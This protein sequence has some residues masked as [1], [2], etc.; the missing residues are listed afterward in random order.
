MP[1]YLF[2]INDVATPYFDRGSNSSWL[3]APLAAVLHHKQMVETA[4]SFGGT[5]NYTEF[6]GD[7]VPEVTID[8][9]C[10]VKL[11]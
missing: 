7:F 11:F 5:D 6:G 9:R 8:G 3:T 2:P 10:T 1:S 4:K